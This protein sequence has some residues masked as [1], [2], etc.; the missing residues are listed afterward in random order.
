MTAG[1]EIM[2]QTL[3]ARAAAW[4]LAA[5]LLE[6]PRPERTAEIDRLSSEVHDAALVLCARRAGSWS[7]ASY[8]RLF[9]PGGT[10]SPREASYCGFEDPGHLLAA[11]ES[12][13]RAFSFTP[14]REEAADHIAVQANFVSYLFLKEAYALRRGDA[15]AAATTA[16]AR[17]R[18][19]AEHVG[20]S[21]RGM[22]K[23]M[24]QAPRHLLD[25]V[26][27]IARQAQ[28]AADEARGGGP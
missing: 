17:N 27:W 20:R 10:A 26:T 15:E 18:F 13:Y 6:R 11:L 24:G 4:R 12:C 14:R 16:A 22:R 2:A 21:A 25:V 9:G 23:R 7:E 3:A 28:P 19:L 5:V 8:H 1:G